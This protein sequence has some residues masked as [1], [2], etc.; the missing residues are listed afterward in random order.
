MINYKTEQVER[1][2]PESITC[3][4]CRKEYQCDD[5]MEIQEFQH[6]RFTG[7]FSSIF[8]DMS[9]VELDICQHCLME[10]LGEYIRYVN[11][12]EGEDEEIEEDRCADS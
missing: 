8:G 6:I 12:Y 10:K 9:E 3:D 4:V 5:V 11:L 1:K 7:G 2:V